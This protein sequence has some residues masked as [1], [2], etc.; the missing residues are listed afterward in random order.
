MSV[1]LYLTMLNIYNIKLFSCKKTAP[2][3]ATIS[4]NSQIMHVLIFPIFGVVYHITE[5]ER[6]T[7]ETM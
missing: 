1:R 5:N 7:N 3:S 2:M 4:Q 6:Q